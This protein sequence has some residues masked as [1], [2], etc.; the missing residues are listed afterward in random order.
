MKRVDE[1]GLICK[2]TNGWTT[3]LIHRQTK[4]VS[5]VYLKNLV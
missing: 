1:K 5:R 4:T 2:P 3:D